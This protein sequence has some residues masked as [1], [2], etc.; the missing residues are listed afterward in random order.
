M[1]QLI[2]HGI[3][4]YFL[5]SQWMSDNKTRCSKVA[6]IHAAIYSF[7]FLWICPSLLSWYVIITTHFFIDRYR[8]A[9]YVIWVKN[10]VLD[11][12][13]WRNIFSR[14]EI[15]SLGTDATAHLNRFRWENCSTTGYP[16]DM[17][18]WLSFW[19]LI[20]TDNFLH[21]TINYSAIRWL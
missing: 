4:D 19:L 11:P 6:L 8:L 14:R 12:R 10:L 21:L 9:R 7:P 17:P 2:L 15:S 1:L 3:G 18:P 16:S 5:Q 13:A 20:I